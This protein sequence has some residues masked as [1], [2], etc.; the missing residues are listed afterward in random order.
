MF[1]VPGRVFR[2]YFVRYR[3]VARGLH[4]IGSAEHRPGVIEIDTELRTTGAPVVFEV[5]IA[6]TAEILPVTV[7]AVRRQRHELLGTAVGS[8]ADVGPEGSAP[9]LFP[10]VLPYSGD[11][12]P[13]CRPRQAI[14][15]RYTVPR[16]PSFSLGY[17]YGGENT[18]DG[19]DKDNRHQN[20]AWA[21]GYSYPLSRQS[22]LKVSYVKSRTEESTGLDTE[23]L[24]LGM[25]FSW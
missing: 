5:E 24:A 16:L 10:D 15:N 12:I 2:L 4:S 23:T 20:T 7:A 18:V 25:V 3:A 8:V 17:N 22:G 14:G 9:T 19:D 13:I 21:V 11:I 6:V 1:R